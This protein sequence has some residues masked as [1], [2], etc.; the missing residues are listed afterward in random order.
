MCKLHENKDLLSDVTKQARKQ[1]SS[2][3]LSRED[4]HKSRAKICLKIHYL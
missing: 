3:K 1:S 4:G 2:Q